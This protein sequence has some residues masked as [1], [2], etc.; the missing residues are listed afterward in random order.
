VGIWNVAA[1]VSF[2][3]ELTEEERSRLSAMLG[4]TTRRLEVGPLDLPNAKLALGLE[5]EVASLSEEQARIDAK[6]RVERQMDALDFGAW[7]V[8]VVSVSGWD[9]RNE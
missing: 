2:A 6:T 5:F 7:R 3:R 9:P 8:R 4:Q 1:A